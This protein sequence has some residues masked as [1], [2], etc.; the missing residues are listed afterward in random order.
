MNST[1]KSQISRLKTGGIEIGHSFPPPLGTIPPK[2]LYTG[3]AGRIKYTIFASRAR[4][5]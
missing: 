4:H 3:F 5:K 2:E 1:L